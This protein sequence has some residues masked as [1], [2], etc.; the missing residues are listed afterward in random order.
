MTETLKKGMEG[1]DFDEAMKL[2]T[3]LGVEFTSDTF[4]F[5]N[6]KFYYKDVSKIVE[7]NIADIYQARDKMIEE[8]DTNSKSIV[9]SYNQV[10]D[11]L[12]G[13]NALVLHSTIAGDLTLG[14]LIKREQ[15][16]ISDETGWVDVFHQHGLDD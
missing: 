12:T 6:G 15:G 16:S 14:D 13:T 7:K 11:L 3:E 9:K 5:K 2:A 10:E 8:L 4:E 1:M